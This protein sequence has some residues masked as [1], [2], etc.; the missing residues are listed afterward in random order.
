ML[1]T[2]ITSDKAHL[3]LQEMY[4]HVPKMQFYM[5]HFCSD[6]ICSVLFQQFLDV[7][8][9]SV[10]KIRTEP[11]TQKKQNCSCPSLPDAAGQ[12]PGDASRVR[13]WDDDYDLAMD[14]DEEE[15]HVGMTF[16]LDE[17][18]R[19]LV[20]FLVILCFYLISLTRLFVSW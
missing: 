17:E 1:I 10:L 20:T 8:L 4:N 16:I 19:G 12:Q 14:V 9:C 6:K 13:R 3:I 18:V 15:D 2:N 11:G 7:P 5:F